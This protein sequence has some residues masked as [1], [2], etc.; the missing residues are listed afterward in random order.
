MFSSQ[1]SKNEPGFVA[2]LPVGVGFEN[3]VTNENPMLS[4]TVL[5]NTGSNNQRNSIHQS[6]QSSFTHEADEDYDVPSPSHRKTSKAL[7]SKRFG[8]L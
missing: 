6:D 1:S 5:L 4:T 2:D 8:F 7:E 3:F